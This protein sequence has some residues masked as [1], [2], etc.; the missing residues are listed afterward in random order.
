VR[1][2]LWWSLA[3]G[4]STA[5][6]VLVVW[7]RALD[8]ETGRRAS[9]RTRRGSHFARAATLSTVAAL[10]CATAALAAN[11]VKGGSYKGTVTGHP[12]ITVTFKVS[13]SGKQVTNLKINNTPL[14]C[15]GGGPPTPVRFKNATISKQGTFTS[16]GRYVIKVGPNKGKVGTRLKITGEFSK[17]GR[18]SG[19][20]KTTYSGATQCGGTSSYKTK[21]A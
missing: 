11:A 12:T 6:E 7:I 10:L 13:G 14:Y 20:L 5:K 3:L 19:S 8:D 15:S 18:E 21:V 16:T 1:P 4:R 17:G 9:R 2:V